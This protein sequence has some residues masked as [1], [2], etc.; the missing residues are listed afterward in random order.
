MLPRRRRRRRLP[1]PVAIKRA[2]EIAKVPLMLL[3]L[4][5]VLLLRQLV[6]AL[7]VKDNGLG[8]AVQIDVHRVERPRERG[9]MR[10][11]RGRGR[12]C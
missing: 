8:R 7:P 3:V 4:L 2:A 11:R 12:G 1:V 10:V 5:P 6:F 9:R